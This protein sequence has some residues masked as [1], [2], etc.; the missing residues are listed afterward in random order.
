MMLSKRMQAVADLVP[1][2]DCL[3][4]VGTDHGY[5][6]IYLVR[7]K[8]VRRAIA[9][10][11]NEG[12]LLR[13]AS[14]IG[15]AG[16]GDLISVRQS[17]GLLK[18][19]RGE[20]DLVL[21]AGMGGALTIRILEMGQSLLDE[22]PGCV[23]ALV[24]QPQSEIGSVRGYLS[25]HGWRI[26]REDM[27]LEDGK[28]YPMMEA[29]RGQERL[30]YL[31]QTYGPRLLEERNE[32]LSAYLRREEETLRNVADKLKAS[33]GGRIRS[34]LAEVEERLDENRRAQEACHYE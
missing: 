1:Q 27:V 33:D 34:R 8:K 9:M 14:H 24:L 11:V 22:G 25:D 12:P 31:Q 10:D 2:G 17:D 32:T 21:I 19:K 7:E 30:T 26:C 15:E 6:P 23:K 29:E 16:L 28:F 20:A 18:L 5:L 3:A 4:D 13:A